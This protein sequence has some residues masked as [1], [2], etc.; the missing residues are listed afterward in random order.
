M[1]QFTI[2]KVGYTH[3]IYGCSG[4][5][6]NCIYVNSKGLNH[7]AFTGLYGPEERIAGELR[8]R[9]YAEVYTPT[10]FGLMTTRGQNKI[11]DKMFL[12]EEEAVKKAKTV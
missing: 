11:M 3:S 7:F 2:L 6:F 10:D 9:G 1:K 12:S 8:A 4:E 5:Y